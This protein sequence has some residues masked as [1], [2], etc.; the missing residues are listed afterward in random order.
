MFSAKEDNTVS[1]EQVKRL[2]AL[3]EEY[4]QVRDK[5]RYWIYQRSCDRAAAWLRK[6][7]SRRILCAF[8][9]GTFLYGKGIHNARNK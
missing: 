2:R 4:E 8:S 6:P 5:E 3:V 9:S 1:R 7:R